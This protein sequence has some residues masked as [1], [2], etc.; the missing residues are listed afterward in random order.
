MES[1]SVFGGTGFVGSRFCNI[2]SRPYVLIPREQRAPQSKEVIYFISTTHN[3][4]VFDD[5]QKDVDVNLKVLL[6]VL[7]HIKKDS[8]CVFNFISSWFVYGDTK[9]P[10]SE[11]SECHPKGF[12]SITKR[13]AEQLLISYC[14]TFNIPYRILRL[15]NV[16]GPGDKGTSKQKNALQ[17]LIE[18]LKANE[19]IQLYHEGHFYRDYMHVSDV[20]RAIDLILN[21]AP[22]NEIY[23]IGTGDKIVFRDVIML[24]KE[25]LHS[26]SKIES[27]EPPNFHK[28]VQVKD[29]YM[30]TTKLKKLGFKPEI[31]LK[32]GITELCR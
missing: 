16:Y 30:D 4:H 29:F 18:K 23:N 27:I 5:L 20:A 14:D 22:T 28:V 9:L 25:I 8:G 11:S 21:K 13:A 1:L 12:Y 3:Y 15:C 10:A 24:A 6:E 2:T 17:F 26:K 19:V 31:T 32:E 7:S